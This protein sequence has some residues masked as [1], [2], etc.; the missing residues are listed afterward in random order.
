MDTGFIAALIVMLILTAFAFAAL[1]FI[2]IGLSGRIKDNVAKQLQSY[3]ELIQRKEAR[4]AAVMQELSNEES[5]YSGIRAAKG[6][7][8]EHLPEVFLPPVADY[9]NRGFAEDYRRLNEGFSFDIDKIIEELRH[10]KQ[11]T[12][13]FSNRALAQRSELVGSLLGKLSFES[14]YSL[15]Q[16]DG[17]E[18]LEIIRG[19]V[20]DL[21]MQ[22]I[23]DFMLFNS[24][25]D[26]IKFYNWLKT[27]ILIKDMRIR[28]KSSKDLSSVQLPEDVVFEYDRNLCEGFQI[29]IGNK[30]YD[31]GIR[32]C[33]LT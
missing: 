18:Q 20:S 28:I 31:Y 10:L 22:L 5:K 11:N 19:I 12:D 24:S 21:E 23:D 6:E 27:E 14:I 32:R 4:L 1:R 3:D 17:D 30:L 26:C 25:F 15:S 29:C 13:K 9:F 2:T 7:A 8:G 16:V 33:E